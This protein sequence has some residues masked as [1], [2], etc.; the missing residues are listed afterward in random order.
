MK[1]GNDYERYL[2][3][4]DEHQ[5]FCSDIIKEQVTQFWNTTKIK[6]QS[7]E[8]KEESV[9][10]KHK[11]SVTKH[12]KVT[13][14]VNTETFKRPVNYIKDPQSGVVYPCSVRDK[15]LIIN[16]RMH[17][18]ALPFLFHI[19]GCAKNLLLYLIFFKV[20]LY[21]N[22]Y[23]WNAHIQDHFIEYAENH[24]K[25]RYTQNTVK[26]AHELLKKY[27]ITLTIK[28]GNCFLNPYLA[29][30][31]NK[32]KRRSLINQYTKVL[33]DKGKDAYNLAYP[34]YY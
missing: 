7:S 3:I 11:Y 19:D 22:A 25:K 5:T 17:P 10:H 1:R 15:F 34:K 8:E 26:Q 4:L 23:A 31:T 32:D 12:K 30:C 33:L 18:E 28:K 14:R 24:H 20:D 13:Q 9:I 6:K 21:T 29:S 2:S 27:K 16:Y